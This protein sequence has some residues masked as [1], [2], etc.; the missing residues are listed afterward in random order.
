MEQL[1]R[2]NPIIQERFCFRFKLSISFCLLWNNFPALLQRRLFSVSVSAPN[3]L[4]ALFCI[5]C[6]SFSRRCSYFILTEDELKHNQLKSSMQNL[7][8]PFTYNKATKARN[9]FFFFLL[10]DCKSSMVTEINRNG[11]LFRSFCSAIILY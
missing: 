6:W 4:F 11:L 3:P 10:Y 5:R 2:T 9:T 7:R 1:H 8:C